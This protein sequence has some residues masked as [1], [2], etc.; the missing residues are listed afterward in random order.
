MNWNQGLRRVSAV[1]WSV[2]ALFGLLVV[3]IIWHVQDEPA[4]FVIGAVVV[5]L[6]AGAL[7]RVTSWM[8]DGF[9][10]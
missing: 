10:K 3:Q 2:G 5:I 1:A 7:H 8:I 6:L 4:S 9:T